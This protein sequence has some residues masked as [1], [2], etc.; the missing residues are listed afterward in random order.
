VPAILAFLFSISPTGT[1]PPSTLGPLFSGENAA[2]LARSLSTEYPSRVPG[3]EGAV[4]A[5]RWYEETIRGLGLDADEDTWLEDVA[6]LGTVE[7]QNV[8]TVVPGRSDETIVVVAHRDNAG[9]ARTLGDNASGTG[10]LIELARGFAPQEAG[11]APQLRRTLVLVSTDAGAYGGAG[12]ER[13]ARTSPLARTAIA[14]VVLD[15]LAGSGRPRLAIAGDKPVS[16]ARAL[17]RTAAARVH[18][19]AGISPE[20]PS[21]LTQ[22]VDLGI[23]FAGGEQGR[24]LGH[25]LAALTLT[26]KDPGD[27]AIPAGDP[28]APLD[29][30]RLGQLGR[31]TESLL[32]SLDD[33]VGGPFRT[34]DSLFIGD[35]A[36]SGWSV[37][38]AL[39]LAIVPFALG[40]VDLIVRGR[41]HGLPFRPALRALRARL[42]VAFVGGLL[43]WLG[44][45]VGVFP[46]GAPLP[47]SP[48]ADSLENPPIG[49]L[50]LLG[51]V[52]TAAWLAARGRLAP[53]IPATA[54][55][56]LAGLAVALAG[57]GVVAFA[58]ALTKPYALVFVLPSLYAWLWL[59]LE[60]RLWHRLFLFVLGL[61]G[62][63]VALF[64][65][66]HEI[67]V[68]IFGA[69]LYAVGLATVGYVSLGSVLLFLVWGAAAAQ[70]GAL[71]LGRYGPYAAGAEPPPPGALRRALRR[72]R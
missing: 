37:R 53:A 67:G 21:V 8:V 42:G 9:T 55:E 51:C 7:L 64:V 43:V 40:L 1:L 52:F 57:V 54:G 44:T 15:G 28:A 41:R 33:S 22:L 26:T 30:R 50:I 59:P 29:T 6:D 23:P 61:A 19:Q 47:L 2:S 70:V 17:V 46:T 36:A 48:L 14:T 39:V 32:S 69:A 11:P 49:G 3:S 13:F 16:P 4:Q 5:T 18:E 10:A 38:L 56:R 35:R 12:A 72:K 27:P 45:L 63:I 68:S 20:L 62:P 60:R 71:A 24:F 25:D 34:P 58:L 65:L 31:A 66:A